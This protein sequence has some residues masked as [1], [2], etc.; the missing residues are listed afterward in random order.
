VKAASK[1][2]FTSSLPSTARHR[3]NSFPPGRSI[4]AEA[5]LEAA[6]GIHGRVDCRLDLPAPNPENTDQGV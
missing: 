1:I 3:A 2:F 4:D 6:I 5:R